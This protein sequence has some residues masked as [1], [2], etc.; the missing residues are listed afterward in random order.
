MNCSSPEKPGRTS[1]HYQ[2]RYEGTFS[3]RRPIPGV[4]DLSL[5]K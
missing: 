4:A 1:R 2:R 5:A 3:K